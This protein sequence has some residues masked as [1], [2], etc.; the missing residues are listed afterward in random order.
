MAITI[1]SYTGGTSTTAA[2]YTVPAGKMAKVILTKIKCVN[3]S[4]IN[5]GTYSRKN[6]SAQTV[7]SENGASSLTSTTNE[8]YL[9]SDGFMICRKDSD[10][11]HGTM[12]QIKVEHILIAGETVRF[13]NSSGTNTMSFKVIEEDV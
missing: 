12:M 11:L 7:K 3:G 1:S 2:I 8:V 6:G 4:I 10:N 5:V 9:E 13:S